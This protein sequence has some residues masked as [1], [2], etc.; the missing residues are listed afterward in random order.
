MRKQLLY[1]IA[2]ILVL[3][4][5]GC[6]DKTTNESK[7]KEKDETKEGFTFNEY[8]KRLNTALKEMGDKTKLKIIRNEVDDNG[9]HQIA[10]SENIFIFVETDKKT[11]NVTSATL[12]AV[13]NAFF[14]E[15]EDLNFS[16][17]LLAGTIDDSLSFS[18][19]NKVI[20]DLGLKNKDINIMDYTKVYNHNGIQYT[21]KGDLKEDAIL[22]QATLK[23]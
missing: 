19:R 6:S 1:F 9:K 13:S 3:A 15:N 8:E 2:M 7:A 18:D 20:S 21:Y 5:V 10:L 14:T 16:F 4:L 22:L 23:N 11:K 17:L 12:A